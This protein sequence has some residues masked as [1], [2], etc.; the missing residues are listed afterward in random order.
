MIGLFSKDDP[1]LAYIVHETLSD[2]AQINDIKYAYEDH[3]T[4]FIKPDGF[5]V[6]DW[7]NGAGAISPH[8]DDLYEETDTDL[9]SLTTCRDKLKV[10]TLFF[11]ANQ[12]FK[13]LSDNEMDRLIKMVA[14]FSFW[15][16]CQ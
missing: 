10:S 12:I 11:M 5:A 1:D 16:K 13:N 3:K 14:L 7:G 9:L 2:L 15:K 6:G 4:I 8:C